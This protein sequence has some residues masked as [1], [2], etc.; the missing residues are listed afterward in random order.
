MDKQ[1]HY[2]LVSREHQP[3]SIGLAE[4]KGK[5]TFKSLWAVYLKVYESLLNYLSVFLLLCPQVKPCLVLYIDL[6]DIYCCP[7]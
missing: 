3:L 5:H 1:L 2:C 6:D 7:D 4:A